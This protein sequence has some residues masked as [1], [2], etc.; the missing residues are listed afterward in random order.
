MTQLFAR[1]C[2]R[3]ISL[4]GVTRLQQSD[5]TEG[6]EC[7]TIAECD[8][9]SARDRALCSNRFEITR[10]TLG[11][12]KIKKARGFALHVNET[13]RLFPRN[14]NKINYIV[15]R[16]HQMRYG[17]WSYIQELIEERVE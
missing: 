17:D 8:T 4:A 12:S 5:H 6:Y 7:I 1:N 11:R 15:A 2:N 10:A 9:R 13:A 3:E 14:G 16:K